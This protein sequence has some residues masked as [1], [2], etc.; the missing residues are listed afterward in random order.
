MKVIKIGKNAWAEGLERLQ[1]SCRL[2]GPVKDGDFYH[3]KALDKGELPDFSMLNTRLSPKSIVYPQSEVMFEYSLDDSREDCHVIKETQIEYSPQVVIGIRPCD[4]KAFLLVQRNFETPEYKDPYWIRPYE[5]TTLVGLACNTPCNTCFCMDAGTGPFHEAGLDIL[6]MDAGDYYYA[7]VNTS[8]GEKIL[9]DSGWPEEAETTD[10][11]LEIENLKQTAETRI[12]ARMSTDRLK[13]KNVTDLFN[14]PF[15]E[16][17]A[18]A[19]IN[20]GTCTYVCPTCWCFDVQDEVRGTDGVRMRNWDSCMYPLFTFHGSGHNPRDTK[21]KRL[22]QRFMHKLKYYVD[23][24]NDGIQCVGCG[25]C[26]NLCPVN[27]DVRK[28]CEAMNGFEP[29]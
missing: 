3:F 16:D 2:I 10:A 12:I 1:G 20:C 8:K 19:C 7:R 23:K 25:R 9:K 24:Y 22:R 13:E 28:I 17:F 4:A 27:I 15:W 11:D 26:I 29:E 5:A 21:T 18:F 6:L 14:A